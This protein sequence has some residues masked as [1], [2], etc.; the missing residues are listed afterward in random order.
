MRSPSYY[1]QESFSDPY[2]GLLSGH[3]LGNSIELGMAIFGMAGP[4]SL[5][6]LAVAK[7]S[8]R[9]Q[10]SSERVSSGIITP[11]SQLLTSSLEML[12]R[13]LIA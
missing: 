13:G 4:E 10:G 5:C 12:L 6:S 3:V 11:A 9:R 8:S 7:E 1:A 2:A